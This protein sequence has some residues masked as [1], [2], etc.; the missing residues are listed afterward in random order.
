MVASEHMAGRVRE[1]FHLRA[2]PAAYPAAMAIPGFQSLM[3]PMLEALSDRQVRCV[4]P[5]VS[6]ILAVRLGL[7][8]GCCSA[9]DAHDPRD[10]IEASVEGH[11]VVDSSAPHDRH[12]DGISR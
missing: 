12:M 11:D 1:S 4:V 7:A 10:L 9:A 6:D 3:L 8:R 2:R 5:E